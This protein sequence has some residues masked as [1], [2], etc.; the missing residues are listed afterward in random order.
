MHLLVLALVEETLEGEDPAEAL[1]AEDFQEAV[2]EAAALEQ[3][4]SL[5]RENSLLF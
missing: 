3:D 2:A 4:K 1:V 5:S